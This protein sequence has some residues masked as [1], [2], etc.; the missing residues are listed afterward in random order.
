MHK[1]HSIDSK[2]W[3][4]FD[5][6]E[7]GMLVLLLICSSIS[8]YNIYYSQLSESFPDDQLQRMLYVKEYTS[9]YDHFSP[10]IVLK[11]LCERSI[12]RIEKGN[13]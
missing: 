13:N 3:L 5:T 7:K 11:E 12:E 6:F 2:D 4:M 10:G 9:K 8:S 1:L